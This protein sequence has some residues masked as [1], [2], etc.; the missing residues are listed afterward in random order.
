MRSKLSASGEMICWDIPAGVFLNEIKTL[1]DV[2]YTVDTIEENEWEFKTKY[3]AMRFYNR[4]C[5][6]KTD[7]Q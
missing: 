5:K 6:S 7:N 2:Y 4:L 1:K 3:K